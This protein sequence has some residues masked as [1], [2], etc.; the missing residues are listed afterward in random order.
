MCFSSPAGIF[1]PYYAI[2][3]VKKTSDKFCKTGA[4]CVIIS[5]NADK[6]VFVLEEMK[7]VDFDKLMN[8]AIG[9]ITLGHIFTAIIT[10]VI[11]Y[12][13]RTNNRPSS[14][15]SPIGKYFQHHP[16]RVHSR[17][18]KSIYSCYLPP[19]LVDHGGWR[20]LSGRCR[21]RQEIS[22]QKC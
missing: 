8:V 11:G 22:V 17:E 2:C 21:N 20:Y 18:H 12:S 9:K 13:I 15:Q 3:S 19:A 1:L 4:N 16:H 5:K 7:I 6:L 14:F 10:F